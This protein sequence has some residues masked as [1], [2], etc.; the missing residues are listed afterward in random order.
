[1]YKYVFKGK[2]QVYIKKIKKKN[3]HLLQNVICVIIVTLCEN[4]V[5]C[6]MKTIA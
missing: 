5:L 4:E 1:M 2:K 3:K 6:V